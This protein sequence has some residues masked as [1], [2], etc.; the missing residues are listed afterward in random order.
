MTFLAPWALAMGVIGAAGAVLLHLV[1]RQRPAAYLLPTARFIP[2]RQ[3]LV[4][5]AATRPTDL[6]LLALRVLLLLAAG[7]AFA[8]PV[9]TSGQS[10]QGRIILLDRSAAVADP[11]DAWRRT[12]VLA[13]D[14]IPTVLIAFDSAASAIAI[15]A[16]ADSTLPVT[17]VAPPRIG[18]LTAAL[19]AARRAAGALA[20]R[21]DSVELVLVSPVAAEEMDGATD[22]A[23]ALW[24]AAVRVERV[25]LRD[26][27]LGARVLE[28]AVPVADP[29]GAAVAAWPVRAAPRAVR[30][31][32]GATLD[33]RDSAFAIAGGTVVLWDS[34]ATPLAAE[35][36][37]RGND[38]VVATLG[39]RVLRDSGAI[40]ARWADGGAAAREQMLGAGCVRRVGVGVPASGDLPLRP[41]F[42]RVVDGLL[43]PCATQAPLHPADSATLARLNRGD[44]FAAAEALR[45]GTEVPSPIVPWLLGLALLCAVAELAIRD[46][47]A[48]EVAA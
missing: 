43:A 42:Q 29:L 18:S 5:R 37:T 41:A 2:D 3:T 12:R 28:R 33:A 4:S 32:R 38:V 13:N 48:R 7:A 14:G 26:D 36:L 46:R 21:T 11:A 15:P 39:R 23:R 47:R 44:S 30:L 34:S 17:A 9:L 19:V 8:R 10:A 6:L 24:P 22:A 20:A 16:R 25:A 45:G 27:S 1:S 31:R 35:G 40:V